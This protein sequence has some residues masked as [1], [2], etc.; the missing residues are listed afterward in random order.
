ML[1][2]YKTQCQINAETYLPNWHSLSTYEISNMYLETEDPRIKSSCF[3]ALLFRY[4]KLITKAYSE[5]KAIAT[6]EDC[7]DWLVETIMYVLDK[8]VWTNPEHA[9]YKKDNAPERAIMTCFQSYQVNYYVASTR[10]K[11]K[12]N[13][14]IMSLD[15]IQEETNLDAYVDDTQ[16]VTA[17]VKAMIHQAFTKRKYFLAFMIDKIISADIF[18]SELIDKK[19]YSKLNKGKLVNE[20]IDID[21]EYLKD[22]SSKY[23]IDSKDVIFGYNMIK[24]LT[25][26]QLNTRV[27]Q[28]LMILKEWMV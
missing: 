16:Y 19:F 3:S 6:P 9:L 14:N 10:Q 21:A 26:S 18:K 27:N 13:T 11:R 12:L 1:S 5:C 2:E 8:H 28:N 17:V 15:K 23:D 25:K 24:G 4:W 20:L 7:Y 22:F